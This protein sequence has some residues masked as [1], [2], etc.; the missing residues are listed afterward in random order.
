MGNEQKKPE[1]R[2]QAH[3]IHKQLI[4]GF[5]AVQ[6]AS[7]RAVIDANGAV[8]G[9]YVPVPEAQRPHYPNMI[10]HFVPASYCERIT[11]LVK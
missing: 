7:G 6:T 3:F 9:V 10:E 11:L 5:G 1:Q 8:V 2:A 4:P